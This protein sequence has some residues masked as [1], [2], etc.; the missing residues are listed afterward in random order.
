M[1]STFTISQ[2]AGQKLEFAFQRNDGTT[3]DLDWLSTG[4]NLKSVSLLARGEAELVLKTKPAPEPEQVIDSIIRVNRSIRPSYPDWMEEVMHPELETIG[5][6][7]YDGTKLEQWLHDGQKD[8]KW[9]EGNKIYAH[10]KKTDMLKTCLGLRDLEEIQKKGI[11]YFRKHFAGKAVFG[12]ASVVRHRR[13]NLRVPYLCEGGD[14]VI[15]DWD[16]LGSYWHSLHPAL[17]H[18]SSTQA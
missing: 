12:W 13:G 7:E 14:E 4:D 11:A 1:N 3:S 17:R 9:I 5:P 2:G 10:L 6:A 18:A 15:L 8:G 16:W